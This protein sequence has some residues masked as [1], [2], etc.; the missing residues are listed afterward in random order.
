MATIRFQTNVP[1]EVRL[2]SMEGRIV[3]SQFGGMQHMFSADEGTFYVSEVVG[4]ILTEQFQKLGIKLGEPVEITKAEVSRG[5][6]RKY[7]SHTP[8]QFPARGGRPRV[9]DEIARKDNAPSIAQLH[10]DFS[11]PVSCLLFSR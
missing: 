10:S 6:G 8:A 4:S 3:E 11:A 7:E 2:R 9:S 5:G 1:V